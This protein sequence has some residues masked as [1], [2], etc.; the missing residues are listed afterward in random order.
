MD[1]KNEGVELPSRKEGEIW[2]RAPNIM[3]G[4]YNNPK[5][6]KETI[7]EDG[8]LKTGDIGYYNEDGKWFIV[9]RMKA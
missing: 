9:D 2:I 3:K 7:T 5:A 6:T 8:W 4:Y 1:T